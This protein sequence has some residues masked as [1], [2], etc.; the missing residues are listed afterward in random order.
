MSEGHSTQDQQ[1]LRVSRTELEG[2]TALLA[3]GEVD[4]ATGPRLRA[5]LAALLE[6][7]EP[8]PV[9]VD[10][11][12]VTFLGSTGI[13]VL[14]DAHWQAVQVGTPL[15]VVV[16]RDGPVEQAL[17]TSGVEQHLSVQHDLRS[18]LDALAGDS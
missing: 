6:R 1:M 16:S 11:T 15:K 4:L 13:A 9:L 5:E 2:A 17:R 8:K 3:T 12:E 14:V 7:A 10:L 18:A